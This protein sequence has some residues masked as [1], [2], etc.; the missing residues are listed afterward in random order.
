MLLAMVTIIPVMLIVSG[1]VRSHPA[2]EPTAT[3]GANVGPGNRD[4]QNRVRIDVSAAVVL[5]DLITLNTYLQNGG[6]VN[7]KDAFGSTP[8]HVA[9]LFGRSN[10]AQLLLAADASLEVKNNDGATPEQLLELDWETTAYIAQLVQV[11]VNPDAVRA[12]REQIAQ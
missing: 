8:M 2:M 9:C 3:R 11:P 6:D 4:Q 12:G 7:E 5:G 1:Y 10:V